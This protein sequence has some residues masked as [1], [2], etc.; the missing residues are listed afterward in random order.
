MESNVA[1]VENTQGIEMFKRLEGRLNTKN[2]AKRIKRNAKEL[3]TVACSVPNN[4]TR[5]EN[6]H[7][8][9]R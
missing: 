9:V 2:K 7:V 1:Q 8:S 6:P 3:F 4:K 5:E